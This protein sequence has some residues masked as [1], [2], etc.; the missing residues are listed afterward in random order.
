MDG[1]VERLEIAR[2]DNP[3]AASRRP[4][5][6]IVGAGFGGLSAAT[7]LARVDADVTVIDRRN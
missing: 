7:R 2:N 1:L 4:S 3:A 5:I 6:V